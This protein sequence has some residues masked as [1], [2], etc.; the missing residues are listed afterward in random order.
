VR[1][2]LVVFNAQ[3]TK[4]SKKLIVKCISLPLTFR[5]KH[6]NEGTNSVTSLTA[7]KDMDIFT[8]NFIFIPVNQSL[9]W[10][11]CVVVN[12]GDIMNQVLAPNDDAL[13]S[14]LFFFDSLRAHRKATITKNVQNWLNS[15][16]KRLHKAKQGTNGRLFS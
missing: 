12:P 15:E 10:S 11:L 16:W 4:K 13:L 3:A 2:H 1:T 5:F 14:C 7:K 8:M 6:A 9:H